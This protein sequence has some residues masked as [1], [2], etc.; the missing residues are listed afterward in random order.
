MHSRIITLISGSD[1][2]LAGDG[3]NGSDGAGCGGTWAGTYAS[4]WL[5]R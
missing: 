4:L 2:R 1:S 3:G 5:P